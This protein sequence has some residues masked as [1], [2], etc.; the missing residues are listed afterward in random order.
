MQP[1]PYPGP[2]DCRDKSLPPG[3]RRREFLEDILA[4]GHRGRE[5]IR[6]LLVYVRGG[7][8]ERIRFRLEPVLEETVRQLRTEAPETVE[9]D[10]HAKR[11]L[12]PVVGD[13]SQMRLLARHLCRNALQALH[14]EEGG[15]LRIAA[16]PLTA[17]APLPCFDRELDPGEWVRLQV[18]DTGSGIEA[19]DRDRVFDPFFTTRDTGEGRGLG[20]SV[21]LGVVHAHGGGIRIRENPEGG[22][23]VECFF[24]AAEREGQAR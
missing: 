17:D 11:P 23:T 22:T 9:I 20:L 10:L 2:A 7:Q 8:S 18:S 6:Q 16:D 3:D 5:V 13:R 14:A 19:E 4:A 12:P 15:T 21:V 24:P 1:R